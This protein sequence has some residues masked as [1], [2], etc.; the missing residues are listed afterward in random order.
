M[1]NTVLKLFS[2]SFKLKPSRSVSMQ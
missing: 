1:K 2:V